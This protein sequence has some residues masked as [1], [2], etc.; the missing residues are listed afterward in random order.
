MQV[1]VTGMTSRTS[2]FKREA[3]F[4]S[5]IARTLKQMGHDVTM[6]VEYSGAKHYDAVIAGIASPLSP[7]SS[8]LVQT[9]QTV[10]EAQGKGNLAA[11]LVDNPDMGSI[12]HASASVLRSPERLE[13][14]FYQ[15]RPGMAAYADSGSIRSTVLT[16]IEQMESWSWKTAVWPGHAW[17]PDHLGDRGSTFSVPVDPT[18]TLAQLAV[19][20]LSAGSGSPSRLPGSSWISETTYF[21]DSGFDP[22]VTREIYDMTL[23]DEAATRI[24]DV[25][26]KSYG[27][28]QGNKSFPGWWTPT[29]CLAAVVGRLFIAHPAEAEMLGDAYYLLPSAVE[30]LEQSDYHAL[31][32]QQEARQEEVSWTRRQLFETLHG[33]LG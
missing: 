28:I 4:P 19:E 16:F 20:R 5:L 1:L 11:V 12:T 23:G 10:M 22:S 31:V 24:M 32:K 8:Y 2:S 33:V 9:A 21:E 14:S 7:S 3:A 15:K 29:P 27:I 17:S 13:K 25:Y 26:Q 30:R 18:S 6:H